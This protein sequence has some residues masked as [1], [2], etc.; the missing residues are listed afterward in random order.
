MLFHLFMYMLFDTAFTMVMVPYNAILSDMTGDYTERTR[1]TSVR[2]IFS[3]TSALVCAVVP[4]LLINVFGSP[5]NGPD[6]RPGYTVMAL[7]F[8]VIFGL[9]WILTFFGTWENPQFAG[10]ANTHIGFRDWANM[11]KNK[12]YRSFLGI[13]I[14][15]QVS[16]DLVLALFVFFVDIVLMKYQ[17]YGLVMGIILVGQIFYM[18]LF[19]KIAQIKGKRFP[20]LIALP[21]WAITCLI[22]LTYSTATPVWLICVVCVFTAA[23]P[24]AGNV[25]TWSML[26]DL[27]DVDELLTSKRHEGL[28]SGFTTFIY[29]L[30]SGLA[31][32]IIGFGLQ[33][34]GFNQQEYNLLKTM[35]A[36]DFGQYN[37]SS[38]VLSIKYMIV[39]IPL[40]FQAITLIFTLRYQLNNKRFSAVKSAI[41]RFK[42]DGEKAAF[43]EEERADLKTVTGQNI[44]ALWG[45][46][47]NTEKEL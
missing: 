46:S 12:S 36:L 42:R 44:E 18:A 38:I 23:G 33:R 17:I 47:L 1:F 35:G 43:T 25:C 40:L 30:S 10:N 4:A 5:E 3:A 21:V 9:V 39:F 26:S 6:Q 19:G 32:L 28:Y 16:I 7:I 27:F 41:E 29:K 31:I 2:M 13:F 37:D 34:A 45:R 24:A 8:G 14:F 20:L 15:V 11:F 22:F